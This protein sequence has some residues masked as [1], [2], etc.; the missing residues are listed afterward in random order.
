RYS[1]RV[2]RWHRARTVGLDAREVHE[3]LSR[4]PCDRLTTIRRR[5]DTYLVQTGISK[6]S[7]LVAV[8]K[9]LGCTSEPAVAMGGSDQDLE[10]LETA[11]LGYAPANCS[12]AVREL[13][14]RGRCR[15]M[16]QPFQRGLLAA[17]RDVLS[18]D[19]LLD[20]SVPDRARGQDSRDLIRALSHVAE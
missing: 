15:V 11:E 18:R 2:Y 10:A 20:G 19:S 16:R 17:V 14:R 8:K 5:N 12:K 9:Y 13:A 7:A 1:V 6:G 3:L 4:R